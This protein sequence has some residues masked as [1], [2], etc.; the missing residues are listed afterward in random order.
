VINN[1]QSI[2]DKIDF[3]DLWKDPKI[4]ISFISL[5][6]NPEDTTTAFHLNQLIKIHPKVLK[7]QLSNNPFPCPEPKPYKEDDILLGTDEN[8]NPYYINAKSFVKIL[9]VMGAIGFG[10]TYVTLNIILQLLAQKVRLLVIDFKKDLRGIAAG[11]NLVFFFFAK[12]PTS[13]GTHFKR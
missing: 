7:K 11:A 10:K 9:L 6:R 3:Y 5:A 2:K 8:N 12:N 13:N 1:L 4:L